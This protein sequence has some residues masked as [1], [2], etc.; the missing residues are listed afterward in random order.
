MEPFEFINPHFGP[1]VIVDGE[2]A[3]L[4]RS[5]SDHALGSA[6]SCLKSS[7]LPCPTYT[8]GY[9][10]RSLPHH[11]ND[12]WKR[13]LGCASTR[14]WFGDCVG[15]TAEQL[16]QA[17]RTATD[18]PNP[19]YAIVSFFSFRFFR[20]HTYYS[21]TKQL[22]ASQSL[23]LVYEVFGFES[24]GD[25]AYR[26]LLFVRHRA[27]C[28]G[29]RRLERQTTFSISA[30][31][32][33]G[34]V[35]PF[36]NETCLV[37][38]LVVGDISPRKGI[39]GRDRFVIISIALYGLVLFFRLMKEE[40]ARNCPLAKFLSIRLILMFTFY[41]SFVV[42][43]G[44]CHTSIWRLLWIRSTYYQVDDAETKRVG[45]R[46][47]GAA[48][49]PS[50]PVLLD[51]LSDAEERKDPAR[52]AEPQRR[53]MFSQSIS[54]ESFPRYQVGL[55]DDSENGKDGRF[56]KALCDVLVWQAHFRSRYSNRKTIRVTHGK[57]TSGHNCA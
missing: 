22:F 15:V 26:I 16:Y 54:N 18:N 7:S 5:G 44:E 32:H 8:R 46:Y 35:L 36:L 47:V 28:S 3:P 33:R 48:S 17:C 57:T 23:L 45:E 2:A 27:F 43:P 12:I 29:Y 24:F 40:L 42:N 13:T 50:D 6:A 56:V 21:P 31:G 41:Q 55:R 39:S 1:A 20:S 30:K 4:G 52:S 34:P 49:V 53:W 19:V 9:T 14:C 11:R 37:L 10:M 25:V 51:L 38:Q